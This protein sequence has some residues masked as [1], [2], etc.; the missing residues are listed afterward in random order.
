[1][2]YSNIFYKLIIIFTIFL[3]TFYF[4][5]SA[6]VTGKYP[7]TKRLNS[8]D[9]I[10]ISSKNIIFTDEMQIKCSFEINFNPLLF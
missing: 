8:G 6:I 7:Y 2:I 9:Y 10:I 4:S 5:F 1:M 3:S